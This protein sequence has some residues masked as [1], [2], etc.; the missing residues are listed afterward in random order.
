MISINKH[1]NE[2]SS[3][4]VLKNIEQLVNFFQH[5]LTSS[6]TRICQKKKFVR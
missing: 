1:G 6:F 5:I 4:D 3:M 2:T